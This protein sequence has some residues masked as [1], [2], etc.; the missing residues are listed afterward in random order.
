M[1]GVHIKRGNLDTDSHTQGESLGWCRSQGTPDIASK[2][3]KLGERPGRDSPSQP[4]KEQPCRHTD[5][6]LLDFRNVRRYISTTQFTVLCYGKPSKLIHYLLIKTQWK[7]SCHFL[8]AFP[9]T[10]Y[11]YITSDLA[12]KIYALW[13]FSHYKE[14]HLYASIVWNKR[15]SP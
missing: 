15:F 1:I 2:L 13:C 9:S 3:P 7:F 5:L 4:Q 11:I 12:T 6:R 8:S 10:S 14:E